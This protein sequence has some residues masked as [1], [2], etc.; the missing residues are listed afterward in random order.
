[1][2]WRN[3]RK[4]KFLG[5]ILPFP[6]Y[7]IEWSKDNLGFNL[8]KYIQINEGGWYRDSIGEENYKEITEY[9]FNKIKEDKSF[10]IKCFNE[11]KELSLQ[12]IEFCKKFYNENNL[13]NAD[14]EELIEYLRIFFRYYTSFSNINIPPW[15]FLG[16]RINEELKE[17]GLSEEDLLITSSPLERSYSNKF[18]LALLELLRKFRKEKIK[19]DS[20]DVF[21]KDLQS[22]KMLLNEFVNLIERFFWIPFDYI[23]PETYTTET[24]FEMMKE[25]KLSEEEIDKKIE[26]I[27][28]RQFT[29][30]EKQ[31]LIYKKFDDEV[32]YL[33][34]CLQILTIL[35]D[36]KKEFTTQEHFYLQNI[37]KEIAKRISLDYIDLYFLLVPEIEALLM[38]KQKI[39]SRKQKAVSIFTP[40]DTEK[41]KIL[42]FNKATEFLKK[43]NLSW[44]SEEEAEETK[45]LK[46]KVAS[47]GYA[48]GKA[49]ILH[50]S[51]EI[52]KFNKGDI[53]ITTMTTPDFVPIMEKAAAIITD[54]G[55]IT[56]HAAIISR[57]L[58]IPCIVG[59]DKATK[60]IKDGD[61]LEVDAKK[62]II[63]ILT[64]EE[65]EGLLK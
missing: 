37:F 9:L 3:F 6:Y 4:R 46:G 19:L 63:N 21:I 41:I 35:Q 54:E 26:E 50:S 38:A 10:L 58:G 48:T 34:E 22:N 28:N 16:D 24:I 49:K 30:K 25:N 42:T 13:N 5:G 39:D 29:I 12:F 60:I 8:D 20:F 11:G 47:L 36:N 65:Y 17:R 64:K 14:D 32:K 1:M 33:S 31:E 2:T 55:G 62:G 53:L 23:G 51:K 56:S 43:N 45:I 27:K 15:F 40:A 57:E 18:D 61:Y 44:I 7:F 52:S 59:T